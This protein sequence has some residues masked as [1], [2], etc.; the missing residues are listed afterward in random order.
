VVINLG[1]NDFS[2]GGDPPEEVFVP[3]YVAFLGHLRDVYPDAFILPVAPTLFGDEAILVA[4]YLQSAV[5]QRHAD[6][7]PRRGVRRR[8]RAVERLGLR[9]APEPRGA[10]RDGGRGSCEELQ[11]HLGW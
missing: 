11:A 6:G 9:R 2:T 8:Q 3:A 1:T 7:R 4:G 10:R 5:D